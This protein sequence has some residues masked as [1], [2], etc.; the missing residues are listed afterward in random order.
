MLV[1]SNYNNPYKTDPETYRTSAMMQNG[2]GTDA[3][4]HGDEE[5]VTNAQGTRW[6]V[7]KFGGTSV[8]KFADNVSL[9]CMRVV[10]S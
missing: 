8:G 5:L 2:V 9:V 7:Q 4:G 10:M 1:V 3:N 6:L